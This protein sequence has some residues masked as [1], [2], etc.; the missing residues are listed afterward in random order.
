MRLQYRN[1]CALCALVEITVS[2]KT[3][4]QAQSRETSFPHQSGA[5]RAPHGARSLCQVSC[6]SFLF[7]LTSKNKGKE[8]LQNCTSG[9]SCPPAR[10]PW[11]VARERRRGGGSTRDKQAYL[12]KS[13]LGGCIGFSVIVALAIVVV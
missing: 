9:K 10:F 6:L 7:T 2:E 11:T 1:D 5:L 13:I 4:P 12:K 3:A 8:A